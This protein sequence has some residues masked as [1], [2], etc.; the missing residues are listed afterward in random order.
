MQSSLESLCCRQGLN[1]QNLK[2]FVKN[3]ENYDAVALL[4]FFHGSQ[5][6]NHCPRL[7]LLL[8]AGRAAASGQDNS[9]RVNSML[10]MVSI[11][12]LKHSLMRGWEVSWR[13]AG[14][15]SAPG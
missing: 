4:N 6:E 9:Y 5:A 8:T 3:Q 11:S 1:L 14:S 2:K 10:C 7:C 12:L 13:K 15:R